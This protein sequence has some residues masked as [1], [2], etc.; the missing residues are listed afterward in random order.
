MLYSKYNIIWEYEKP[1]MC[2]DSISVLTLAL[3]GVT[4]YYAREVGV[5]TGLIRKQTN[6]LF[7]AAQRDRLE[8]ELN[9]LITPIEHLIN[10]AQVNPYYWNWHD[11]ITLRDEG[12]DR[13]YIKIN[14]ISNEIDN[15]LCYKYLGPAY[16]QAA[17]S[18]YE[19]DLMILERNRGRFSASLDELEKLG[20]TAIIKQAYE[21]LMKTQAILLGEAKKRYTEIQSELKS[22]ENI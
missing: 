1:I 20:E 18:A 14:K 10:Y 22:L 6:T 11:A 12:L 7:K 16:L 9:L 17:I 5:Q 2:I 8:K 3:V 21:T 13:V 4:A 15:I 19:R